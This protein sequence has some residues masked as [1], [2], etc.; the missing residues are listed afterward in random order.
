MLPA[1]K[2]PHKTPLEKGEVLRI[3]VVTQL[4]NASLS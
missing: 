4:V 1:A 2:I 3:Y